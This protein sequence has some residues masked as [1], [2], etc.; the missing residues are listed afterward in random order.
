MNLRPFALERFFARHEFSA[1]YLLCASDPET[2]SLRELLEL[3]PG[4][5]E[6][7]ADLLLGYTDS[8]GGEELRRAVGSCY[9][10][11]D[12]DR[13]LVHSGAEEAIFTFMHA[14]LR[15]GDHVV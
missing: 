6:R 12:P 13:I 15:A 4:A 11:R 1:P 2:L 5:A 3:E 10:N 9:E 14:A 8:R 7:F